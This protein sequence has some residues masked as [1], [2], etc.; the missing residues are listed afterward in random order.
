MLM[1]VIGITVAILLAAY[2]V[3]AFRRRGKSASA[4]LGIALDRRSLVHL[5]IGAFIGAMAVSTVFFVEWSSGL[6]QV[7]KFNAISALQKDCFYFIAK[8]FVEEFIF[9]CAILGA[10][11]LWI[12][13]KPIALILSAIIFGSGH[14]INPNASF[15]SILSTML[16]GLAYGCAFLAAERIWFPLGLHITWNY[17]QARVFGFMLSGKFNG[18]APFIQQHDLGPALI[19]GG[20]Y[21]PEGGILGLCARIMVLGLITAWVLWERSPNSRG[22]GFAEIA[23]R[24]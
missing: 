21:G 19:T 20:A 5:L 18:P 23:V 12:P 16:G 7:V 3:F 9:R 13:K 15:I 10:L 14:L 2:R 1:D 4:A 17:C 8:P 6:L 22:R 24:E 11:L